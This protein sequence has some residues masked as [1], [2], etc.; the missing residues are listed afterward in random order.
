MQGESVIFTVKCSCGH[1][2]ETSKTECDVTVKIFS[3][4]ERACPACHTEILCIINGDTPPLLFPG[5]VPEFKSNAGKNG[6]VS[7]LIKDE[8]ESNLFFEDGL[9]ARTEE[10]FIEAEPKAGYY[11]ILGS[12]YL[13]KPVSKRGL[14][15]AEECFR[16]AVDIAPHLNGVQA[17]IRYIQRE[18]ERHIYVSCNLCGMDDFAK[19]CDNVF[20]QTIVQCKKC[21]LIYRNLQPRIESYQENY[22]DEYIKYRN[23]IIDW[24]GW[25]KSRIENMSKVGLKDFEAK[26]ARSV[27]EIGCAEGNMLTLFSKRGWQAKGIDISQDMTAYAREKLGMDAS[28]AT[29]EE[30]NFPDRSFD[31]V[32][33]FHVIEHLP[34]PYSVLLESYRMLKEGGWVILETPCFDLPNITHEWFNDEDHLTFFSESTIKTILLKIGFKNIRSYGWELIVDRPSNPAGI[35]MFYMI[36]S[37]EKTL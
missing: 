18:R 6:S 29:I 12:L 20:G 9:F 30:T 28:C 37:A 4:A 25:H 5:I 8:T 34:D 1:T 36:V 33:M 16:K 15:V 14:D 19:I 7:E 27:L 10:L 32:A 17:G 11:S 21:G 24:D 3:F 22:G 31:L 23:N 35:N 13:I 26:E 2:W